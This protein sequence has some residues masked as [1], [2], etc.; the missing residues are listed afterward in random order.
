M[1][2]LLQPR[3]PWTNMLKKLNVGLP[4]S[5]LW[6]R[7]RPYGAIFLFFVNQFTKI[8]LDFKCHDTIETTGHAKIIV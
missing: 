8:A 1:D 5:C 2:L 7:E 6:P 4:K 3:G